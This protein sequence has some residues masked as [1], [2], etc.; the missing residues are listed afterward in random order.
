MGWTTQSKSRLRS[1]RVKERLSSSS[2]ASLT[3]LVIA[4]TASAVDLPILK[5]IWRTLSGFSLSKYQHVRFLMATSKD[6][7]Y[8]SGEHRDRLIITH[9]GTMSLLE[10]RHSFGNPLAVWNSSPQWQSYKGTLFSKNLPA[11]PKSQEPQYL[12]REL[13]LWLQEQPFYTEK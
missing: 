8:L 12:K 3:L 5:P 7:V 10:Y 2:N 4:E 11:H 9:N 13:T 1:Q 6:E